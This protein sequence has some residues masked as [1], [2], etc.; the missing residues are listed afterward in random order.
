[1][2]Q[3]KNAMKYFSKNVEFNSAT[4]LLTGIGI[5]A[6][7]TYPI[8][9]MHP[10]RFGLIFIVLGILGHIWAMTHKS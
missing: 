5:G 7:L 1:M 9:G 2:K 6:L 4:H 8:A 3:Y 10:V